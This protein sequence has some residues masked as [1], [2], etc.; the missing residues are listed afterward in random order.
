MEPAASRVPQIM[1]YINGLAQKIPVDFHD[2]TRK[3]RGYGHGPIQVAAVPSQVCEPAQVQTFMGGRPGFFGTPPLLVG[4]K[5]HT[6]M[7][8]PMF[9]TVQL[10]PVDCQQVFEKSAPDRE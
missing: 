8:Q 9:E 6:R 1:A 4:L 5:K 3:G 10:L 2:Q 7:E